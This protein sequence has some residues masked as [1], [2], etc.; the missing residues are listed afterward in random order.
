LQ[1]AGINAKRFAS[2][3]THGGDT[4]GAELTESHRFGSSGFSLTFKG[5]L[6]GGEPSP[7]GKGYL[8]Q[9]PL[10]GALESTLLPYA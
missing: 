7:I 2:T 1:N 3:P 8:K 5:L 9:P 10:V 6:L 4:F